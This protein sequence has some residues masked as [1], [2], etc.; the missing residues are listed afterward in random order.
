MLSTVAL[1]VISPELL[2]NPWFW[3]VVPYV[4]VSL[5]TFV[6]YGYD[7]SAAQKGARRIPEARLHLLE[8]LG[9]W[10]GALVAQRVFRHKT[11]KVSF[12]IVFW[13]IGALHVGGWWL[14][15]R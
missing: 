7:K 8:L 14:A 13:L 11:R 10:P 2:K 9:G 4:V 5:P 1:S 6:I 15:T 3:G 12:Q